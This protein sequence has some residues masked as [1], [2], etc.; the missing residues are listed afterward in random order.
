MITQSA[1]GSPAWSSE[2]NMGASDR[3]DE[4]GESIS[5]TTGGTPTPEAKGDGGPEIVVGSWEHLQA[6]FARAATV[7]DRGVGLWAIQG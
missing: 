1:A 3:R 5:R 2:S 6:T 4:M 7:A